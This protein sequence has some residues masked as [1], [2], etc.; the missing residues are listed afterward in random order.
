MGGFP[1]KGP[2]LN[3]QNTNNQQNYR[4][5]KYRWSSV[6]IVAFFSFLT[7]REHTI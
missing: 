1:V 4:F 3:K 7:F 6:G 2:D 5:P